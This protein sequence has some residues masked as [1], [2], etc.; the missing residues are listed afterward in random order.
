[1][2]ANGMTVKEETHHYER[3][4][5]RSALIAILIIPFNSYWILYLSY[6]FDSNRP[7]SIA[8]LFNVV[9]IMLILIALNSLIRR[10]IPRGALSQV[11]LLTIYAMLCQASAFAGRDM[12]Q[13]LV[14]LLGN[15]FWYAR[16]E[17]EWAELFHSYLPKWLVVPDRK[18]LRGF[19]EGNSSL[20]EAG[21]WRPWVRPLAI[22]TGFIGV[23]SF[24][25]L[26]LSVILRK[27]WSE[28]EKLTYPIVRL[29][30]EMTKERSDLNLFRNRLMWLGFSIAS[31]INAISELG[32]IFPQIPFL[33]LYKEIHFSE[34]PWNAMNSPGLGFSLF[35]FAIG[36]GYLIPL[37]LA[38]SCWFF[39]L[40]WHF[41]R[42]LGS[43]MGWRA[44]G[45]PFRTAQLQGTWIG[46][47]IFA[48]WSGRRY[49]LSVFRS[50][51]GREKGIDDTGEAMRYRTAVWGAILGS[52]F[53]II[54][55][56]RMG[57]SLWFALLFFGI[58]LAMSITVTRVR[59]ELGPPAHDFYNAGPDTILTSFL[60]TRRIGKES[61]SA[62]TLFFWINHL[63]YR[64][65]PMPHQL[66]A[67][68]LARQTK[69]NA[70][71]L[72]FFLILGA[73]L[74]TITAA[75]GHLHISYRLGLE[76]CR[77]WYAKA[78]YRRLASWMYNPTGPNR[79]NIIFTIVG[80]LFT[81]SLLNLRKRFLWFPLHPVGYVVSSWWTFTGLWFPILIAWL[82][83][84]F[85]LSYGGA[86][87]YRRAMPFFLGLIMGDA[88][89]ASI[90]SIISSAMGI[91]VV[92]LRW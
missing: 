53:M 42:V 64:A 21:H 2:Y 1:M 61:L 28:H 52:T 92:Y 82:S 24:T 68:W 20:Y 12:I 19:Y 18:I 43:A 25:M 51:F 33:P 87:G 54:F 69:A 15:G 38:F 91:R 90:F 65:H 78:A 84:R 85:I 26:C 77:S 23:M 81:V 37:D 47:F 59:A 57:M 32:Q 40:F 86:K 5:F 50:A 67:L 63:S 44:V 74:G 89:T 58:Y 71:R 70:R 11:E 76:L 9:F 22:W 75:W 46:L 7:T 72:A 35:P 29:P 80:F 55:G 4:S 17:N 13:V 6:V 62:M 88:V 49:F 27:Q 45:F 8:L 66:E 14:P 73:L 34:K 16:P 41:E 79:N 31:A 39:H 48:I 60:G 10:I 30:L 36:L 56:W 83:K 3:V